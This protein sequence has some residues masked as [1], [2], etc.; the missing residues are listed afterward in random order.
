MKV[1]ILKSSAEHEKDSHR[2]EVEYMLTVLLLLTG[3][4]QEARMMQAYLHENYPQGDCEKI[5]MYCG[6]DPAVLAF[7]EGE[8]GGTLFDGRN[9]GIAASCNAALHHAHG[10]DVLFLT[11]PYFRIVRNRDPNAELCSIEF[12]EQAAAF[13]RRFAV[14]EAPDV[15]PVELRTYQWLISAQKQG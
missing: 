13:A 9:A 4:L 15:D 2:N 7:L 8:G 10:E 12:D 3:D 11:A 1:V 5:F 14:V 6:N